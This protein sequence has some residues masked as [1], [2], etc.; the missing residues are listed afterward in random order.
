MSYFDQFRDGTARFAG[1]AL[2]KLRGHLNTAVGMGMAAQ[3]AGPALLGGLL[4]K[5]RTDTNVNPAINDALLQARENAG[6]ET[7]K[8]EHYPNTAGGAAG[9][10]VY[11]TVA[12]DE[13]KYTNG[14]PTGVVQKYDTDKTP[15]QALSETFVSPDLKPQFKPWKPAEALLSAVQGRG[16]TTHDVSFNE[17]TPKQAPAASNYTVKSG[18]TL[19]DIAASTGVSIA[20]LMAKNKIANANL[21]NVGQTINY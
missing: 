17:N 19:T 14:I 20:D 15:L 16:L 13:F 21:I 11:G 12:P 7:V 1:Q 2:D 8:Y 5:D 10:L 3:E 9:K 4:H 6:G 18:D